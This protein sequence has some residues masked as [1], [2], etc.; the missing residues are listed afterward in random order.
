MI[1]YTLYT[2]QNLNLL[3][4]GYV[5]HVK[6]GPSNVPHEEINKSEWGALSHLYVNYFISDLRE[7]VLCFA[8]LLDKVLSKKLHAFEIQYFGVSTLLNISGVKS[9]VNNRGATR[10]SSP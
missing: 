8:E 10:L 5:F 1:S 2:I 7:R 9:V 4:V 6:I 3:R